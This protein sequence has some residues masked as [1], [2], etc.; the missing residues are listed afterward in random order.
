MCGIAG[1]IMKDGSAADRAVLEAMRDALL[2]RGPDGS[3]IWSEGPVGFVH[4]RLAIIDLSGGDHPITL[5]DGSLLIGNGEIYNYVEIAAAQR[6]AGQSHKTGADFEP[7]LMMLADHGVA[8]TGGWRGMYVSAAVGGQGVVCLARDPFGIKPLSLVETDG[9]LAFASEPR[10]LI[11][12]SLVEAEID[13]LSRTMLLQ[14]QY[15]PEPRSI[16]RGVRRLPQGAAWS[17]QGASVDRSHANPWLPETGGTPTASMPTSMEETVAALDPVLEDSVRVHQ[18]SDVPYGMFLSGGIDSSCLL[19]M[20]ARLNEKPVVAYTCGFPDGDVPDER[21]AAAAVAKAC[22]ADHHEISFTEDDFWALLPQVAWA[23][24]EP[25]ADYAILPS[26]AL[27]REAKSQVKVV[28]SGEG[29]DEIF[30]G[31]GRY[32]KAVRPWPLGRKLKVKGLFRGTAALR[33]ETTQWTRPFNTAR[34]AAR[35]RHADRLQAAQAA[36]IEGWLPADLLL[37]LDRALMAHGV[38]GRTPFL[39]PQVAGFGFPLPQKFK[40]ENNLGKAVLRHWLAKHCP[41]ADAFSRKKGFTVPVGDWIE[42]RAGQAGPLVA[43]TEA[44]KEACRPDVVQDLFHAFD[45]RRAR[46]PWALL[47]WAVWHKIHI[48]GVDPMRDTFEVLQA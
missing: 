37:K 44:V 45:P 26:W 32:R 38:E 10:A 42:R 22:G 3:A 28:L 46:Q 8:G 31:Y 24:D 39:D 15:I 27:A 18:R 25:V 48:E 41:A 2:H 29:G 33:D 43:A 20:M 4:T 34:D 21:P 36:D 19:A 12:A 1:I 11:A 35:R 13:A 16:F 17:V 5:D 30:G 6:A 9:F 47:F 14:G 7:A 23:F 40:I